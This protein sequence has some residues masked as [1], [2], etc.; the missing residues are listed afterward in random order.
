LRQ[1]LVDLINLVEDRVITI[2]FG[3]GLK[4]YFLLLSV[5]NLEIFDDANNLGIDVLETF[6][7]LKLFLQ[8]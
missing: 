5:F 1:N 2:F 3:L 8:N 6:F 4:G 7:P